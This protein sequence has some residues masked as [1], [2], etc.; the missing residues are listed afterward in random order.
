MSNTMNFAEL[1]KAV[2]A[3]YQEALAEARRNCGRD[4]VLR[5]RGK[6]FYATR[7]GQILAGEAESWPWDGT[8][9]DL[10]RAIAECERLGATDLHID[11]GINW[12]ASPAAFNDF[13]YDPWVAEWGVRVWSHFGGTDVFKPLTSTFTPEN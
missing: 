8:L 12:A 3:A 4:G 1:K 5:S 2:S 11:G 7:G 6:C 9:R 10:N 13:D